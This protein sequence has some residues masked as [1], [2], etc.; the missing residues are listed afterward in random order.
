MDEMR[1]IRRYHDCHY[2]AAHSSVFFSL[3]VEH[4]SKIID[5]PFD[6]F[7]ASRIK[8]P[9]NPGSA[10]HIGRF[11]EAAGR[12]PRRDVLSY[13]ASTLLL[14]AYPPIMHG[15]SF[16]ARMPDA[17][18]LPV[19]APKLIFDTLYRHTTATVS[20]HSVSRTSPLSRTS[21]LS[22]RWV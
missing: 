9:V 14:D 6:F 21:L 11:V 3:A 2:S 19:F 1:D 4:V 16:L 8:N 7:L 10:Q 20:L 13:I 17:K 18:E 22:S 5:K 12:V 15:M